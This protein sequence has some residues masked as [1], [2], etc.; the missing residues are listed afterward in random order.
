MSASAVPPSE[1]FAVASSQARIVGEAAGAGAPVVFLHAGV[2]DRRMWR[3]E[4][5]ALAPKYRAIAYDRRGFGDT[6]RV[7]EPYAHVTDLCAVLDALAPRAPAILVG[8]SQGGRV[9][10]DAALAHPDRVRALVLVAPA[11]SG[12]PE[13]TS[14]PPAIRNWLD[15]VER[16]EAAADVDRIN[17]LE[18]HAWLDGPLAPEGRVGG[19]ARA[20]F[21]EMNELALRAE[22]RG[23]EIEPPPAHPRLA[24]IA[25]PTLVV[26]GDL[27]FP[28][29]AQRCAELGARIPGARVAVMRN[30]AHLPNLEHP[31][32]F[33]RLLRDFL[34]GVPRG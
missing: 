6:L 32:L 15:N 34:D 25:S 23:E 18:A 7:D 28:H 10:V 26:H 30:A 14:F 24:D 17:E 9:A 8:C 1:P 2:A 33:G 16:A 27:D 4:L 11:I 13:V 29:I 20:L 19:A 21:L 31:A 3:A 22:A 12:A 5:A